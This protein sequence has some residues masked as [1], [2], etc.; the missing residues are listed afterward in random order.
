MPMPPFPNQVVGPT[1][2]KNLLFALSETEDKV[3]DSVWL[4]NSL[5]VP[6]SWNWLFRI[7]KLVSCAPLLLIR[8]LCPRQLYILLPS[9]VKFRTGNWGGSIK[10][11]IGKLP[12]LLNIRLSFISPLVAPLVSIPQPRGLLGPMSLLFETTLRYCFNVLFS[13]KLVKLFSSKH[14]I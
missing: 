11:A 8:M 7:L 1:S 10:I 13:L 2:L 4:I 9:M 14:K 3:E 6:S 5:L 12:T